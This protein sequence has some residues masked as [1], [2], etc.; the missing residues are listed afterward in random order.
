MNVKNT[1]INPEITPHQ[2]CVGEHKLLVIDNFLQHPLR[3]Q[4]LACHAAFSPYPGFHEKK[5]YP[6][7]RA[8][9]PEDYSY[10]LTTFLE[11][12]LKAEFAVPAQLDIRKSI[13]AF[14]LMTQKPQDLGPLQLTPHFD[15]SSQY[16][17]AVLLYLCGKEHG[18][19]AFYR[20][21][22]TGLTRITA[23]TREQ[24]LDSYY[25]ELN[26]QRPQQN[27]FSDSTELFSK[28]G[29][30]EARFNRLVIYP[31]ALL[32]APYINADLSIS[33]DPLHGR[34]TLN[35]FFDF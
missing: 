12:L 32:H 8:Q 17:L 24:Y 6:G 31:G 2:H 3:M 13:C 19:T 1:L 20:H 33:S 18:G 5:G 25:E 30:I 9:A 27:Y 26:Q 28:V 15:A 22:A 11:P 34:L 16:H 23:A 10:E 7:I 14:S 35:S 29:F 21:N 4:A